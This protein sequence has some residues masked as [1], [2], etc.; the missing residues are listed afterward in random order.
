[1]NLTKGLLKVAVLIH[2]GG[3]PWL[4]VRMNCLPLRRQEAFYRKDYQGK[5]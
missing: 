3:S 2:I 5:E 1:M 4:L